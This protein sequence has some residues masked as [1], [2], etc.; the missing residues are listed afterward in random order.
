VRIDSEMHVGTFAGDPYVWLANS[1]IA[2]SDLVAVLDAH[3]FDHGIVVAP[4][5][6]YADNEAVA[7]AI[8]D[9]HR[10]SAF[11]LVNPYGPAGGV[12]ELDQS[13]SQL[14]MKGLKLMPLRHGYEIDGDVPRAI[15]SRAADVGIPVNIHSGAQFCL[16]WQIGK[17]ARLFPEM[18]LIMDH[19]GFRYY[20][21]GAIDMAEEHKNIYLQ[22][23]LVS[24][25]GYIRLAVDHLG[26][27]RV[28]YGSDYPTGHPDVMLA[29]VEAARLKPQD[30]EAVLG[31][32][33]ARL[34]AM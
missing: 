28:I 7:S 18:P 2:A 9:N 11:A 3:S 5:A 8:A 22:T 20:V 4:T 12:P 16:P 17:V 29:C 15:L 26:A 24:V 6:Q 13:L 31:G 21:D 23:A 14:G 32:N 19:M 33:L 34:L 1:A 25:P 30:K 27:D 10:L